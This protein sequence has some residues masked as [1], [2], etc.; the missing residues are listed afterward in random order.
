MKTEF[1]KKAWVIVVP[2]VREGWGQVVIDANA[3][4]TPAIAYDV[5][6]L[7]DSIRNEETGL[8]VKENGDV[9]ALAGAIVK[10]L[11]N[12]GLGKSLSKNALKWTKNFDWDKSAEEFLKIIEGVM[13]N[14]PLVS[15]IIP[16][17]DSGK[18]LAKCLELIKD[19]TYESIE[20]I[21]TIEGFNAKIIQTEWK[22]LGARYLG[23][24]NSQGSFH[25]LLDSD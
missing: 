19:Q 6:G 8:L 5:A 3:L 22:L 4:G 25:L 24:K 16:T 14:N 13:K 9:V 17:Y 21:V 1:M 10:V 20:V 2:G 18:T 12:D 11:R 23:L 7:R 15:I